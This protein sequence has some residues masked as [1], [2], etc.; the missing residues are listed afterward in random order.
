[1]PRN[2]YDTT[3][4]IPQ[5]ADRSGAAARRYQRRGRP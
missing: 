5:E 1:M 2:Y 3:Y 4:Q